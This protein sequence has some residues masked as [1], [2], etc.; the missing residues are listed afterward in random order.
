MDN[1][2][3]RIGG[4]WINESKDNTKYISGSWGPTLKVLIFKNKNKRPDSK[5]PD[6]T[7][8]LAPVES[9]EKSEPKDESEPF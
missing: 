9:K 2:L 7:M 1:N 8:F 5:D 3:I 4:L 6:Y